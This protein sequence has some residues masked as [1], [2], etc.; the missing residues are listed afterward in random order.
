MNRLSFPRWRIFIFGQEVSAKAVSLNISRGDANKAPGTCTIVLSSLDD[1]FV[2]TPNDIKTMYGDIAVSRGPLSLPVEFGG[3]FVETPES[4]GSS[5]EDSLTKG[6]TAAIEAQITDP[7]KRRVIL[8]KLFRRV[9]ARRDPKVIGQGLDYPSNSARQLTATRVA[10]NGKAS[11]RDL[12][13]LVGA[14]A[15]YPFQAGSCIFHT[16]DPVRVFLCDP[17]KPWDWYFGFSG[18]VKNWNEAVTE[19]HGRRVTIECEDVL[20]I[21]KLAR[22]STNWALYDVD[23]VTDPDYDLMARSWFTERLPKLTAPELLYAMVFGL[24]ALEGS[25]DVSISRSAAQR[26]G[27]KGFHIDLHGAHASGGTS[28]IPSNVQAAGYFNLEASQVCMIGPKVEVETNKAAS[29][30]PQVAQASTTAGRMPE[31]IGGAPVQD[32][33]DGADA[34]A[35]W[36]SLIDWQLPTYAPRSA[37]DVAVEWLKSMATERGRDEL[38]RLATALGD[39][40]MDEVDWLPN[41]IT[42]IGEHPEWFPVGYGALYV[43]IPS[44]LG[45]GTNTAVMLNDL[46]TGIAAKT[47]FARRLEIIYTIME[48]IDF[49]FYATPKGDLVAEMSLGTFD[50]DDFGAYSDRYKF[51]VMDHKNFS[52][53]FDDDKIVTLYRETYSRVPNYGSFA[54]SDSLWSKPGVAF[55]DGLVPMFGA[56]MEVGPAIGWI[57]TKEAA[58][59]HANIQLSKHNAGAW[60]Y[61]IN[62]SMHPGVGPNRPCY[63]EGRDFIATTR[64]IAESIVWNSSV[65]QRLTVDFRRGWSGL[66][67]EGKR[68]YEPFGGRVGGNKVD[69]KILWQRYRSAVASSK[70]ESGAATSTGPRK[71]SKAAK[72]PT[73]DIKLF[74]DVREAAKAEGFDVVNP[75]DKQE[76]EAFVDKQLQAIPS[77]IVISWAN[78][79]DEREALRQLLILENPFGAAGA[80]NFTFGPDARDPSKWKA[81][82]DRMRNGE[83]VLGAEATQYGKSGA[84]GLFQLTYANREKYMPGG[85]KNVGDMRAEFQGGISYLNKIH[86][87]PSA[88]LAFRQ[89]NGWY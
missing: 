77:P 54:D 62:T 40:T 41:L 70:D 64:T 80:L 86:G 52:A 58:D 11:V 12:N 68:V 72:S 10:N 30:A 42:L 82:H 57:T 88:A 74:R 67:E 18:F 87:S 69:W 73:K 6:V 48:R 59:Y 21:L 53:Q 89:A 63:F 50:P 85:N 51:P 39:R 79:P 13:V 32:L 15:R 9:K 84:A 83:N 33:G 25:L 66:V 14:Y 35:S 23:L 28:Q 76:F 43:L 19:D 65:G 16:G 5:I 1:R 56:R 17:Y 61:D 49:S 22:M 45:P 81:Y 4:F 44:A 31:S 78:N 29:P 2:T 55:A 27:A 60:S 34:L 47:E 37:D 7:I 20:R 36:Q 38:D 26:S 75:F 46:V 3:G 71:T 24:N 8:A